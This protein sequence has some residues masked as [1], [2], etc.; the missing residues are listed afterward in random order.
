MRFEPSSF[1][2]E[3]DALQIESPRRVAGV[4]HGTDQANCKS[5]TW[6]PA[7]DGLL[8]EDLMIPIFSLTNQTD[9]DSI[10]QKVGCVLF[11][12]AN[13]YA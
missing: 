13:Y 10:L 7:G 8:F 4:Y 5:V 3:S 1:G 2:S 12:P 11:R 6:N 9:V